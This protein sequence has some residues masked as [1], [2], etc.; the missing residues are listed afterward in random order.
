MCFRMLGDFLE[1]G[2][3]LAGWT[4]VP[5]LLRRR[6][7]KYYPRK[8]EHPG[9]RIGGYRM[10]TKSSVAPFRQLPERRRRIQPAGYVDDAPP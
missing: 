1:D 2:F 7:I 4:P 5:A 10:R 3:S 9:I 6:G 8:I